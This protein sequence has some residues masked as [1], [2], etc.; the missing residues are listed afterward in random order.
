[1]A[2][3]SKK[4][5]RT[6]VRTSVI[7]STAAALSAAVA[8]LHV[9]IAFAS[10]WYAD[11]VCLPVAAFFAM[12]LRLV[13]GWAPFSAVEI[14]IYLL[15]IAA[16]ALIVYCAVRGVR[17]IRAKRF[18]WEAFGRIAFAAIARLGLIAAAGYL[19][20]A[21]TWGACYARRPMADVLELD[22]RPRTAQD[23]Y[24]TAR[25]ALHKAQDISHRVERGGDGAML[26]SFGEF[27]AD[28]TDAFRETRGAFGVALGPAFDPKPVLM[29]RAMS[30]TS[31]TGVYVPFTG[32]SNVNTNLVPF[33][34]P[35]TMAHELSHSAM[36][37]REDEANFTAFLVCEGSDSAA[38]QYSGWAMSFLYLSNALYGA[39]TQLHAQLWQEVGDHIRADFAAQSAYVDAH[40]GHVSEFTSSVNDSYLKAQRQEDGERSYGRMVDL[41]IAWYFD[42]QGHNN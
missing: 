16:A 34:M 17:C 19:L 21:L 24:E 32:E 29:S 15:I 22:T 4:E 37:A 30:Y 18:S 41:M 7:I 12:V 40:K 1:M 8:V 31:I 3:L 42:A 33:T 6:R 13:F 14:I 27:K 2:V 9:S 28:V 35:F 10:P 25:Y 39:D 38:V 36:V 20:F 5:K 11:T 26:G 23:L